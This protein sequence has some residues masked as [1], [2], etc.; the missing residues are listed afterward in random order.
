MNFGLYGI[1]LKFGKHCNIRYG[2]HYYDCQDGTLVFI[3]LQMNIYVCGA[4][5][6]VVAD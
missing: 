4:G 1:F 2:R 6:L 3:L 5:G